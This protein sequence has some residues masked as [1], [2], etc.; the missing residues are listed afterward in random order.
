MRDMYMSEPQT[1][2][3]ILS[4]RADVERQVNDQNRRS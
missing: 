1:L 3:Q 4:T 2:E